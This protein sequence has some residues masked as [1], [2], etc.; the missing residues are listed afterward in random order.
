MEY[1]REYQCFSLLNLLQQSLLYKQDSMLMKDTLDE[2]NWN[3]SQIFFHD[4]KSTNYILSA[5]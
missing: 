3:L 1:Q 4:N 2:N 5:I